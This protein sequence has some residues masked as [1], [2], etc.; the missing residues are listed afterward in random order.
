MAIKTCDMQANIC[1]ASIAGAADH[2]IQIRSACSVFSTSKHHLSSQWNLFVPT[3]IL[4]VAL[5]GLKLKDAFGAL[6]CHEDSSTQR[7]YDDHMAEVGDVQ[8]EPGSLRS[9]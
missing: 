7:A 1:H 5:N 9:R 4:A 6:I 3:S 8:M 2:D